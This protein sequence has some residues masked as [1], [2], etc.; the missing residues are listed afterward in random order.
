MPREPSFNTLV[1]EALA[2]QKMSERI[3]YLWMVPRDGGAPVPLLLPDYV[4]MT[5]EQRGAAQFVT[6]A[7]TA[8]KMA[9]ENSKKATP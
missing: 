1:T 2:V 9:R 5:P 3:A 7:D 4:A 6:Q 8:I